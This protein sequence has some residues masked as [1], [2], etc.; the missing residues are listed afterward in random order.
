MGVGGV[1]IIERGKRGNLHNSF[2]IHTL[3]H[4][5]ACRKSVKSDSKVCAK[6]LKS[7]R[8]CRPEFMGFPLYS[9]SMNIFAPVES[10]LYSKVLSFLDFTLNH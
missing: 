10:R 1:S 4:R 9:C 8:V 3:V 6:L 7:L 2:R 5:T